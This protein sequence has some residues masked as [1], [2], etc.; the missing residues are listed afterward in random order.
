MMYKNMI[1]FTRTRNYV[2]SRHYVNEGSSSNWKNSKRKFETIRPGLV[3]NKNPDY[4]EMMGP[5]W[6]DS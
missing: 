1:K 3:R 6:E 5:F 2:N 4:K